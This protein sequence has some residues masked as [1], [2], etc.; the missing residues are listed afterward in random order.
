MRN[1]ILWEENAGVCGSAVIC[2]CPGAVDRAAVD[3]TVR[4]RGTWSERIYPEERAVEIDEELD[5]I[6]WSAHVNFGHVLKSY[7]IFGDWKE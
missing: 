1:R 2:L 4:R 5:P 6:Q 3:C 7:G